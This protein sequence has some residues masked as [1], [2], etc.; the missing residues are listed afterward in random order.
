VPG[1]SLSETDVLRRQQTWPS[2]DFIVV[3]L[4][5]ENIRLLKERLRGPRVFGRNG[6]VNHV[7]LAQDSNLL[8]VAGD[9]FHR[10]C[11][12]AFDLVP[13]A[14]LDRLVAEG[15]IRRLTAAA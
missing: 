9:N 7:Q 15:V 6:D 10:E 3:P 4:T 2:L 8:F 1:A 5:I 12:S 14:L 13:K 11:V